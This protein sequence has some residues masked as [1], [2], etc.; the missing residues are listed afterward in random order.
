MDQHTKTGSNVSLNELS[1]LGGLKR[2]SDVVIGAGGIY[3]IDLNSNDVFHVNVAGHTEFNL[4]NSGLATGA[5]GIIVIYN[6]ESVIF[7]PLPSNMK[8]PSGANVNFVTTAGA[9][10]IISYYVYSDENVL[11]NYVGNFA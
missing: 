3:N 5:S 7:A 9:T 8:T 2:S 6:Q 1:L 11:C 10:S 4:I